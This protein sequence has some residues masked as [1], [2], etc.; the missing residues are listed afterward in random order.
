MIVFSDK[1]QPTGT[2]IVKDIHNEQGIEARNQ[3]FFVIR[4]ATYLEYLEDTR[5]NHP[6]IDISKWNDPG[7]VF[8]YEV[9][10]D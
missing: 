8:Y 3:P 6:D 9:S 5:I 10:T 2:V 4:Q 7:D 1:E